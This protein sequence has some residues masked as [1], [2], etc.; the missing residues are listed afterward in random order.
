MRYAMGLLAQ[1]L[2]PLVGKEAAAE[3]ALL[4][5]G[6]AG[7]LPLLGGG[8]SGARGARGVQGCVGWG[9]VSRTALFCDVCMRL[10]RS[11]GL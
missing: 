9:D 8:T 11:A 6:V 10:G 5:R 2:P 7:S 3:V 4:R 1:R